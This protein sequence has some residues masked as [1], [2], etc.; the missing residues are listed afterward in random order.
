MSELQVGD[1][2]R[3]SPEWLASC[4]TDYRRDK[5]SQ[6]SGEVLAVKE[7]SLIVKWDTLKT[8]TSLHFKWLILDGEPE[9]RVCYGSCQE[10]IH[11]ATLRVRKWFRAFV[12][13]SL[14]KTIV[15]GKRHVPGVDP[16]TEGM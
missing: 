6:L 5:Y 13:M 15:P 16:A 4:R 1:R 14:D 10:D 8:P 12:T 9:C 2:V 3:Y 11:A 7:E